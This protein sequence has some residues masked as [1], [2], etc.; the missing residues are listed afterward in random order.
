MN[1]QTYISFEDYLSGEMP[2]GD[3]KQFEEKLRNDAGFHQQF[4][5]YKETTRLLEVKFS[6]ETAAFMQNLK[7]IS[8]EHFSAKTQKEVRVINF[9]PLYYAVAA[10]VAIVFGLLFF[11]QGDP[12]YNDYSQHETAAFSQRGTADAQLAEAQNAFN[13]KDYEKAAAA[14]DKVPVLNPEETYFYAIALIETDRY[15]Q[16]E[17]LL[18]GLQSGTTAYKHKATWYLALSGLKQQKTAQ[19][20]ALL[21]QIPAGAEDYQKAQELLDDLD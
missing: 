14:F 9:R 20:K 2:A 13:A 19:C 11:N 10:S 16:A 3:K 4:E 12:Q 1:E 6:S 18:K 7:S 21:R 8:A 5:L 15:P 17:A